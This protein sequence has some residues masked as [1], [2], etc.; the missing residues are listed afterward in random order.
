MSR[1]K[2]NN[3]RKAEGREGKKK[4]DEIQ[5]KKGRKDKKLERRKEE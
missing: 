4:K 5:L 3:R 1:K 2:E